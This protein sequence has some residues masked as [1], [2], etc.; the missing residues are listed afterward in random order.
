L[1]TKQYVPAQ[2]VREFKFFRAHVVEKKIQFI[3]V[4][5]YVYSL[6][7]PVKWAATNSHSKILCSIPSFILF[8][9]KIQILLC[10]CYLKRQRILGSSQP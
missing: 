10:P 5:W 7:V 1:F 3:R 9:L 6:A 2:S 4:M 8:S